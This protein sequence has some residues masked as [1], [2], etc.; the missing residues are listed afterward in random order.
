MKSIEISAPT[1]SAIP[2]AGIATDARQV[3]VN[4][5][6]TTQIRTR[7]TRLRATKV[8]PGGVYRGIRLVKPAVPPRTPI[9]SLRKAVKEAFVKNADAVGR[10]K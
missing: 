2:A 10:I 3:H 9:A 8:G 1:P 7:A 4:A 6:A 5:M